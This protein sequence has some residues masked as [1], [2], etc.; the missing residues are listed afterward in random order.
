MFASALG[1]FTRN[2]FVRSTHLPQA[3][4][5]C[6]KIIA[7]NV[8]MFAYDKHPLTQSNSLSHLTTRCKWDPVYWDA[9]FDQCLNKGTLESSCRRLEDANKFSVF[10]E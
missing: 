4:F 7:S 5:P 2:S 9:V 3:H 6:T 8:K 10:S 1:P